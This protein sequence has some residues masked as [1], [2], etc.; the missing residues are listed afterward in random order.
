MTIVTTDDNS[1]DSL[2]SISCF[3]SPTSFTT[4]LSLMI[5][6]QWWGLMYQTCFV[7][8]G[9][10]ALLDHGWFT[11]Q[12]QTGHWDGHW[13]NSLPGLRS[14]FHSGWRK[15]AVVNWRRYMAAMRRD[16]IML[17]LDLWRLLPQLYH[18]CSPNCT[19][20]QRL[21]KVVRCFMVLHH[22]WLFFVFKKVTIVR[23]Y[24]DP[25]HYT[26]HLEMVEVYKTVSYKI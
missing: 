14:I 11:M 20:K 1:Y 23:K 17:Y 16:Y 10:V 12:P 13:R 26:R 7:A 2:V 22:I 19:P 5:R 4:S 9:I 3:L 15:C 21:Q 8:I 6:S 18:V 25:R 24:Y